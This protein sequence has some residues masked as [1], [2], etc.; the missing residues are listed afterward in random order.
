MPREMVPFNPIKCPCGC[1]KYIMEP[2]FHCQCS[3]LNREDAEMMALIWDLGL[4]TFRA[5]KRKKM[6]NNDNP[7]VKFT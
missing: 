7:N 1:K 2:Y 4:R 3:S 5:N 6:R